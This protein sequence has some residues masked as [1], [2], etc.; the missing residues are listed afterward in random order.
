[1]ASFFSRRSRL[2]A[3]AFA[4]GTIAFSV[5]ASA[6]PASAATAVIPA[7]PGGG[8]NYFQIHNY[9][10]GICLG[11]TGGLNNSPAEQYTCLS[12]P[13]QFW[14][15]GTTSIGTV[16][17]SNGKV[18]YAFQLINEDGQCLGVLGASTAQGAEVE[19]YGCL[20]S[21]P[22]QY[23]ALDLSRTCGGGYHPLVNL[24]SGM[25][26]GVKSNSKDSGAP[27]VQWGF[28]N[29]CGSSGNQYWG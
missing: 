14:T 3:C 8:G 9:N 28:N 12:H 18:Y 27:V 6:V 2:F 25:V 20:S 10:S 13:D 22:D 17:D 29:N 19:S 5:A 23:W 4:F 15:W 16:T 26:L 24:N 1:M 11:I 7:P 21:H